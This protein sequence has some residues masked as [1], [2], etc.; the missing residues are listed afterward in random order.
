MMKMNPPI[1]SL[2]NCSHKVK[3]TVYVLIYQRTNGLVN[4]HLISAPIR[5]LKVFTINKHG[6]HL[7]HVT[8]TI[9]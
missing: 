6:G 7:G 8:C 9:I 3:Q 1:E 4:A 2:S 5:N